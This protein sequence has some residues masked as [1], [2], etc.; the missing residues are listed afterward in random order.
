[1]LQVPSLLPSGVSAAPAADRVI[2]DALFKLVKKAPPVVVS[3]G[4]EEG[5]REGASNSSDE[6]KEEEHF[7]S[8]RRSLSQILLQLG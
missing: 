1:M 5:G 8:S 2:D 7:S 4:R 3:Q 6:Q